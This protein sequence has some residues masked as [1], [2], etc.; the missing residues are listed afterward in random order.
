MWDFFLTLGKGKLVFIANIFEIW[1][2]GNNF[3]HTYL[4]NFLYT[5]CFVMKI[6]GKYLLL[7]KSF[8]VNV[9]ERGLIT[10]K[11]SI[12]ILNLQFEWFIVSLTIINCNGCHHWIHAVKEKRLLGCFT[13]KWLAGQQ[14]RQPFK[15]WWQQNS[16][17]N[18]LVF[19]SHCYNI[20][21]QVIGNHCVLGR[22]FQC[23]WKWDLVFATALLQV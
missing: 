12:S 7:I 21:V 1:V 22:S 15:S 2:L 3:S 13:L 8:I 6:L 23:Q 4:Q 19:C 20:R 17:L 14:N 5:W 18:V 16:P 9:W 10:I 11:R